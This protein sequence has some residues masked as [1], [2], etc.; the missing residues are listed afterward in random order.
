MMNREMRELLDA[1]EIDDH[2]SVVVTNSEEPSNSFV[3]LP[4]KKL[5]EAILLAAA[6][7]WS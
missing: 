6:W 5:M 3:Y 4:I 1:D 2:V 7:Q